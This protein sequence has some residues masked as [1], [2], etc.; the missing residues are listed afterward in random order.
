MSRL[1]AI[2][3]QRSCDRVETQKWLVTKSCW[4]WHLNNKSIV[5]VRWLR[6]LELHRN[7]QG[8]DNL[9]QKWLPPFQPS[10]VLKVLRGGF[11]GF[12][13]KSRHWELVNSQSIDTSLQEKYNPSWIELCHPRSCFWMSVRV[14]IQS[15]NAYDPFLR[16]IIPEIILVSLLTAGGFHLWPGFLFVCFFIFLFLE[17]PW[18]R[19]LDG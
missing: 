13:N 6:S 2:W 17:G 15:L 12:A 1:L 11:G 3:L 4:F 16:A 19:L 18:K 10:S 14:T 9:V 8:G 7:K 5:L